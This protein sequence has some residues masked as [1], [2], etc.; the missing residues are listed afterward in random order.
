M[1]RAFLLA[2]IAAGAVALFTTVQVTAAARQD[3]RI[4]SF[5]SKLSDLTFCRTGFEIASSRPHYMARFAKNPETK[6]ELL[7]ESDALEAKRGQMDQLISDHIKEA[8]DLDL[9]TT[10][11]TLFIEMIQREAELK[12]VH[13]AGWVEK[14]EV[15]LDHITELSEPYLTE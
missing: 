5:K 4:E 12:A 15:F 7:Q 13:V 2:S 3:R 14:P 8:D 11:L 10:E 1:R 9:D 6:A